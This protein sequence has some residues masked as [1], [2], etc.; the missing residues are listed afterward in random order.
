MQNLLQ[1]KLSQ[2]LKAAHYNVTDAA[3]EKLTNYLLLLEKW[4]QAYNLT[5]VRNINDMIPQHII[6]SLSVAKYLQGKK[7]L[8][9]GTGGGLPGIPLAITH[10]DLEFVLLDSNGKKTRF[11]VNV[12]QELNIAN[13]TVAQAR[14]EE[15]KS[16]RCFDTIVSRAFSSIEDFIEKTK[17]LM[18]KEGQFL[19]MKGKYPEKEIAEVTDQYQIKVEELHVPELNA[20]RHLIIIKN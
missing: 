11:L 20:E 16:D 3:L 14:A 4:N 15:F 17:H 18:C 12:V 7:I 8:D 2:K 13:V 1:N 19:A 10:P 6:D 5:S 9:V